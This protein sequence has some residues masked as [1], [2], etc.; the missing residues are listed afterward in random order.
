MIF[1][2]PSML[3]MLLLLPLALWLYLTTQQRRRLSE[4]VFGYSSQ[5]LGENRRSPGWRRHFAPLLFFLSLGLL[6]V[7][8][9]RPQARLRLPRLEGTVILVMD[10]SG[11]MA[12]KDA[13]P[14]RLEAAK[15]AARAFVT[16]RPETVQ[17][18]IVS[19]SGSGF[20]VQPPTNDEQ[21][22]LAAIDRLKPQSGTSLGQG[23]L[24]ALNTIAVDA[25]LEAAEQ[26]ATPAAQNQFQ[27]ELR[28]GEDLLVNLPEGTF[29]PAVIVLFSDGENNQSIDP[30]RAAQSAAERGVRI[31]ALGFGS[32]AGTIL[33]VEGFNIYT[34]LD[35]TAL[36]Q[37]TQTA[38]GSYYNFQ[39]EQDPKAVFAN[40]NPQLVVKPETMEITSL[41][42]AASG[43]LML[44][45]AVFSMA[46]F[47]RLP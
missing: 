26:T 16:N 24:T 40:L 37:I 25:G 22:L 4:T 10:V 33:E 32:V 45:G 35:E 36:Q 43:V 20:A 15:E 30:V 39:N 12:A 18:G 17:I 7:A 27:Q 28:P 31:D 8:L 46:W 14:T 29:P 47:K 38:G 5:A 44:V 1:L 34:A 3:F 42:A 19:F 9:A 2:W 13:E 41:F 21:M 11:S 23:I 6:L